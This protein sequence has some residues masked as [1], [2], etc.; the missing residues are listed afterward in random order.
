MNMTRTVSIAL[1]AAVTLLAGCATPSATPQYDARY[2]NAVREAML[3]MMVN[4]NAATSDPVAGMDGRAAREAQGR[5]V[6]SFKSPP[7]AM[8]VINIGGTVSQGGQ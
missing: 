5:Y 8:N 4:P 2:G 7:P 6:D 3:R 1:A